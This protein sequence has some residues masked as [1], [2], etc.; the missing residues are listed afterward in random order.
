MLRDFPA[1]VDLPPSFCTEVA[2]TERSRQ[3]LK[4]V[5]RKW[6]YSSLLIKFIQPSGESLPESHL[7]LEDFPSKAPQGLRKLSGRAGQDVALS[8]HGPF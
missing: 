6:N 8:S 5:W 2:A 7:I 4:A 1:G 3:K